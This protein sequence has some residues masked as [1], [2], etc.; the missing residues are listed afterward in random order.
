[1]KKTISVL[2]VLIMMLSICACGTA[3][4]AE[5]PA[6][7]EA[8]EVVAATPAFEAVQ[9]EPSSVEGQLNLLF[10][11]LGMMQVSESADARYTVADLD[12]NGRLEFIGAV[13]DTATYT[14]IA[15]IFEVN[16]AFNGLDAVSLG[17]YIPEMISDSADTYHDKTGDVWCYAFDDVERNNSQNLTKK[18][19]ISYSKGQFSADWLAYQISENINGVSAVSLYD[20][21]GTMLDPDAYHS[22]VSSQFSG[23]ETS[24]TNFDWFPLVEA[25]SAVRLMT[26]YS[27][28]NGT[29][30]PAVVDVPATPAP[31]SAP[32]DFLM[33]TKNPTSETRGEGETC[34]FIARA[35]NATGASWTFL[36]NG[37]A[38]NANQFAQMTGC[39]VRGA[40]TGSLYI[41]YANTSLNN[42]TLYCTFSGNGGQ[43]AR[44]NTVGFNISSK[45]VYNTTTGSYSV[46]GSD[47]FAAAVY[48]P[49]VGKTVYVNPALVS[50]DGIE[51]E[52]CP[53]TV[54][55]TGNVPT[56]NSDGSIYRI[57]VHGTAVLPTISP[58][59]YWE[60]KVCHNINNSGRT[61]PNCGADRYTSYWECSQCGYKLN[62]GILCYNCG[63]SK[64]GEGAGWDCQYCGTFNGEFEVYCAGCGMSRSGTSHIVISG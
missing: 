64:N 17:N 26:S 19:Y 12:H 59:D 33:I 60:C 42:W 24:S 38:F 39:P 56:G 5:V 43:T 10:G 37:N 53:C 35:D 34:I 4:K 49:M 20:K 21:N 51:Y 48:I 6:A 36:N 44:T 52:G 55:Y 32:S 8:A 2:L 61:C 18:A 45:P 31:T 47:N 1:M 22:A 11:N 7:E 25:T 63:C 58:E 30:V 13:T 57:V 23:Y 9:V 3:T 41:D 29:L 62:T 54:Y 16:E 28:F 46:S 27:I 15:K 14:T 40:D 50:Y